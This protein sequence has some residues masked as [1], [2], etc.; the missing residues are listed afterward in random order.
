MEKRLLARRAAEP[1]SDISVPGTQKSLG[2][3]FGYPR[4]LLWRDT[5]AG[6]ELTGRSENLAV[7]VRVRGRPSRT[8]AGTIDALDALLLAA[9]DHIFFS[10]HPYL[11]AIFRR[12]RSNIPGAL[13]ALRACLVSR[14]PRE[15]GCA[16]DLLGAILQG[17]G[18]AE[19]CRRA[20]SGRGP[21]LRPGGG[22][23]PAKRMASA[24]GT[25]RINTT[26]GPCRWR[27]AMGCAPIRA[28]RAHIFP[29]R[30]SKFSSTPVHPRS[31]GWSACFARRKSDSR[32]ARSTPGS[33][34]P[35]W[36]CIGLGDHATARGYAER[37]IEAR[38][39]YRGGGW[40]TGYVQLL[41]GAP[42]AAADNLRRALPSGTR[43]LGE[44]ALFA[45]ALYRAEGADA[46]LA[47]I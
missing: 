15:A 5:P 12:S 38:P 40:R 23:N 17:Q 31:N 22:R 34:L 1:R 33:N 24:P 14:V 3:V 27:Q 36:C 30:A 20:M 35:T 11:S 37:L 7:T 45:R 9:A 39:R 6:G 25:R 42:E 44:R 28:W 32:S 19:G 21:G 26:S 16:L 43:A 2:A 13:T 29:K 10:T 46:A 8:F 41:S 47:F 4:S 18:D